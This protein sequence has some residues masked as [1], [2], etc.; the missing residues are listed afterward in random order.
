MKTGDQNLVKKINKCIVLH[1]I[2]TKSPISRSQISQATGLNKATVSSLVTEL[3]KEHLVHEIGTGQSYGGRKPVMLYFNQNAGYSIGIDLGVNYILGVLTDLKGHII[4]KIFVSLNKQDYPYVINEVIKIIH[5]LFRQTPKSP[6]GIIGI[7]IGVPGIVNRE[8][9]ILFAPNL[10]WRNINIKEEIK[11]EFDLPVIVENDANSGAHGEHIY[12]AGKNISNL[13][14]VNI[15]IGIGTGIIIDNKLFKGATG[16]SGE[17]GH[18]TIDLKGMKCR[19]GNKGCWELYASESALRKLA[20][21]IPVFRNAE[22]IGIEDLIE[23]ANQGNRDVISLFDRLGEYIGIGLINVIN[24]FNPH[25]VIIGNRFSLLKNWILNPIN[26]VLE[27]RLPPFQREACS[28]TFSELGIYSCALGSAA[29]AVSSFFD[30]EK[31]I[32]E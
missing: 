14:Y 29:F 19:C 13:V 23:K 1:T 6:Y 12:G 25:L 22:N 20:K 7:G 5:K 24:T 16:I 2:Q 31:V 15:G 28:V 4:E 27:Q 3:I 17:M 11:K 21:Q 26:R 10:N 9:T 30:K 32:V 18:Q 8:G